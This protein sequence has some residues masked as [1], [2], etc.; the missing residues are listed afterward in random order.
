MFPQPQEV[1]H[2]L[3]QGTSS[4]RRHLAGVPQAAYVSVTPE[5][6][7]RTCPQ[8][9]YMGHLGAGGRLM[10]IFYKKYQF[11]HLQKQILHK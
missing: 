10:C 9:K 7:V 2:I 5:N 6:R 1:A 3:F 11:C 4:K 8:E